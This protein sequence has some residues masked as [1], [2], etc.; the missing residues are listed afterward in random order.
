MSTEL[1]RIRNSDENTSVRA[2][3]GL[4]VAAILKTPRPFSLTLVIMQTIAFMLFATSMFSGW[5]IWK[6]LRPYA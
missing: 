4:T 3:A 1:I 6:K 2:E 5:W